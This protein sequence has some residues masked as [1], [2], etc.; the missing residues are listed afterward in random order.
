[1]HP[2]D[3]PNDVQ[4][5]LPDSQPAVVGSSDSG[6]ADHATVVVGI[7]GSAECRAALQWA[8]HH[9]RASGASVHAIA[10]WHRPIQFTDGAPMP[11]AEFEAEAR[12][13]LAGALPELSPHEERA[14]IE[15]SIEE[16]NPADRLLEHAESADLLILGSRGRGPLTGALVGSV[17]MRCA[18]DARC[19]VVLVPSP[20]GE[21]A[22]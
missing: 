15:T 1:M 21:R 6:Q 16:G 10:V 22:P 17:A 3:V 4:A 18:H 2:P 12:R 13:W 9:A 11:V 20:G 8:V 14:P 19:P 7:D 5:G